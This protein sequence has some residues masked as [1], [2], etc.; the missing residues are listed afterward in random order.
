MTATAGRLWVLVK[1]HQWLI[2]QWCWRQAVINVSRHCHHKHITNINSFSETHQKFT[3][4]G[5]KFLHA[6]IMAMQKYKIWFEN[7]SGV[8]VCFDS[9]VTIQFENSESTTCWTRKLLQLR[10]K[11][12]VDGSLF[13]QMQSSDWACLLY[14]CGSVKRIIITLQVKHSVSYIQHWWRH[15]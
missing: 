6:K 3:E 12:T 15:S 9:K 11:C 2:C 8:P 10:D 13:L 5:A 7:K 4:N 14:A 1:C